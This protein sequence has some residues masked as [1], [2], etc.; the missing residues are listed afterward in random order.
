MTKRVP[1]NSLGAEDGSPDDKRPRR[2]IQD[3]LEGSMDQQHFQQPNNTSSISNQSHLRPNNEGSM[4]SSHAS[5]MDNAISSSST[6]SS[7]FPTNGNIFGNNFYESRGAVLL[8]DMNGSLQYTEGRRHDL[9][10]SICLWPLGSSR[11]YHGFH[12]HNRNHSSTSH[13][14]VTT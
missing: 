5:T 12:H 11:C 7:F 10:C 2:A 1:I 14:A 4:P 6:S 8:P 3:H 9:K 13:A